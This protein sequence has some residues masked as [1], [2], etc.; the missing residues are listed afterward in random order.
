[1]CNPEFAFWNAKRGGHLGPVATRHRESTAHVT[2]PLRA[3]RAI[4]SSISSLPANGA[5]FRPALEVLHADRMLDLGMLYFNRDG[6][7]TAP[8]VL[9]PIII[10]ENPQSL[11]DRLVTLPALTST[12]CLTSLRSKQ[13]TLHVFNATMTIYQF[14][15][16]FAK[17][18]RPKRLIFSP[19]FRSFL[20]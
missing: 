13:E 5:R 9:D 12:A 10:A 14:R 16:F 15:F 2:C 6:R 3:A 19:L 8:D 17:R 4:D 1:M 20:T 18:R 7:L 11:G